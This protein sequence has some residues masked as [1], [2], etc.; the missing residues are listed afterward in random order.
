MSDFN[1]CEYENNE[2]MTAAESSVKPDDSKSN[3]KQS[4]LSEIADYAEL[5]AF[6]LLFVIIALTFVFR[7][8][9]IDGDSMVDTLHNGERII[10]SDFLYTPERGDIVVLHQTGDNYNKPLVKRVIGVA[11]DTVRINHDTNEIVVTD[12]D[13]NS[14]IL[15]QDYLTLIGDQLYHGTTTYYVPEGSL[16]VL[17]DNRNQSLDSRNMY[18]IGYV[19]S[20]R[21][22]GKAIFR[23]SPVNKF[24]VIK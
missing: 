23:I 7:M 6:A 12:S 21:V 17:G 8:C 9:T 5:I 13:G 11:G 20:R 24:G 1:N 14:E 10:V 2:N 15:S 16:F 22:L 19:D 18:D 3:K 4:V